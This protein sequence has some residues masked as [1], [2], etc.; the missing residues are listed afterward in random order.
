MTLPLGRRFFVLL[1]TIGVMPRFCRS[2][3]GNKRDNLNNFKEKAPA[4]QCPCSQDR[5]LPGHLIEPCFARK[6]LNRTSAAS[7]VAY[8]ENALQPTS[9]IGLTLDRI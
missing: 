4:A 8:A 6:Q 1:G 3:R 2:T 7:G 9:L 5:R